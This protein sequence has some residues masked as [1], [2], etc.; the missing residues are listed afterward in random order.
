[1]GQVLQAK[2]KEAT[3]AGRGRKGLFWSLQQ[4][5]IIGFRG[6]D[7]DFVFLSLLWHFSLAATG[8]EERGDKL[9]HGSLIQEGR[10]AQLC[11]PW[12]TLSQFNSQKH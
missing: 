1:M 5:D 2:D 4:A 3:E 11:V 9:F 7:H 6:R 12:K 10:P 8:N